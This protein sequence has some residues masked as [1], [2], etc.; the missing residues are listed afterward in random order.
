MDADGQVYGGPFYYIEYGMGKKW[1]GLQRYFAFFGACVG[2]FGIGTFSQ[3]NGISSAV[4]AFF[5]PK[6]N[7]VN[8]LG[9]DYTLA[10][11]IS[12]LLI[13]I[14]AALVI[15]GVHKEDPQVFLR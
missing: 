6:R 11:I 13:T 12:G 1:K 9:A 4:Q 14:F 5:D 8:I 7:T 3:V 10:V 15:I 2:L